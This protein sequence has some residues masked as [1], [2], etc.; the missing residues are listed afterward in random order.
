MKY[1]I[2]DIIPLLGLPYPPQGRSSY[3][4][5]CPCCDSGRKKHLNIN[6]VKDV[7][8]C[9]RCGFSG[10][11]FDLYSHYTGISRDDV[12]EELKKQLGG[13][14]DYKF[15][16]K[17]KNANTRPAAP[18]PE[19]IDCPPNDIDTRDATYPALLNKLSLSTDH[20]QNLRE[21]G[22]S[23]EAI[24]RNDYKTTPAVGSKAL[25]KQLLADGCY[26]AGVPGFYRDKKDQQWT[27][28]QNQ[29]G[30]LIPVRDRM[31]RLQGL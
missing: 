1:H 13:S 29:R 27:F 9:P 7:F 17:K 21:R 26:L 20:K 19:I 12:Y 2:A 18:I 22:L 8:R 23:D 16:S 15:S 24:V 4:I 25:A 28:T 10:G 11:I 5:P 30:I 31:G 6:L 14:D 3:N